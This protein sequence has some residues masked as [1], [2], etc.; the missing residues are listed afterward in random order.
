MTNSPTSASLDLPSNTR[1]P[2]HIILDTNVVRNLTKKAFKKSYEALI[3][4]HKDAGVIPVVPR[5]VEV[6]LLKESNSFPEF[7]R[8]REFVAE[9]FPVWPITD[10]ILRVGCYLHML[11]RRSPKL[12]TYTGDPKVIRDLIIA[13]FAADF[14]VRHLN[15]PEVA[16]IL[17]EDTKAF[18][19]P[20][21][22]LLASYDI[23][24]AGGKDGHKVRLWFCSTRQIMR[25]QALHAIEQAG[26]KPLWVI[27]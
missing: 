18:H 24:H 22:K 21:F 10:E 1:I 12:K 11:Y 13:A 16:Y 5:F 3:Q 6:E 15:E 7:D 27:S 14:Q 2:K 4:R 8:L 26:L 20:Y 17:S 9:T 19:P 23:Q 25:Q